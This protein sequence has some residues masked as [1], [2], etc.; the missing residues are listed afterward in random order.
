MA[1]EVKYYIQFNPDGNQ[2]QVGTYEVPG[3]SGDEWREAPDNF[4]S[5]SF[6]YLENDEI[7]VRDQAW[8]D[9][10]QL[11]RAKEIAIEELEGYLSNLILAK[12][13]I[14]KQN[15]MQ[16]SA[17]E[18][19]NNSEEIS[20]EVQDAWSEIKVVRVEFAGFVAD[21]NAFTTLEDLN[22]YTYNFTWTP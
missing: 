6:Y 16:S 10:Q 4:N 20:Q 22:S 14:H 21:I 17:I 18:S 2:G 7:K 5:N 15:N 13:P 19:L 1:A 3:P 8:I 12:Y 9:D 11:I